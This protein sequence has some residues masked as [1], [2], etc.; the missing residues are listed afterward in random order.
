MNKSAF[1]QAGAM[2]PDLAPS[3]FGAQSRLSGHGGDATGELFDQPQVAKGKNATA[4]NVATGG[5]A[6]VQR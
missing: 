1:A 5:D 3:P 4:M 2:S 6:L